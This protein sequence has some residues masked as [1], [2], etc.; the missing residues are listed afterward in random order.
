MNSMNLILRIRLADAATLIRLRD[1]EAKG[2]A[3]TA[4]ERAIVRE[5]VERRMAQLNRE[6]IHECTS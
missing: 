3:M 5:E 1:V 6:N 4:A 2:L